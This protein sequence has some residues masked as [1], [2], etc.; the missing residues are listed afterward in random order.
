MDNGSQDG[1][2]EQ[3]HAHYPTCE[4]L[5]LA[6]NRGYAAGMNAAIR[7]TTDDLLLLTPEC[8][9]TPG[10]IDRLTHEL[11]D[12]AVGIVGPALA[13]ASRPDPLFSLGGAFDPARRMQ[14]HHRLEGRLV[15]DHQRDPSFDVEWVDGACL[16]VR[17]VVLEQLGSFDEGYFLYFE[18]TELCCRARRC[19]W[20]VQCVPQA[21][22][23]QT[24][25]TPVALSTRNRLRFLRRNASIYLWGHQLYVDITWV[26]LSTNKTGFAWLPLS[27]S[28]QTATGNP[29]P[30]VD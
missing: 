20:R 25:P 30:S 24:P 28:S 23:F 27:D 5:V 2:L 6:E 9:I 22:T 15:V 8:A 7:A 10:L 29:G 1:S 18:E 19:G 21:L 14:T 12:P 26:P 16:L 17:R 3:I 13:Y 4:V 11:A